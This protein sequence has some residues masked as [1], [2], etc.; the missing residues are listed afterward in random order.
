MQCR[1]EHHD[2]G[3]GGGCGDPGHVHGPECDHEIEDPEG[4]SLYGFIDTSK[5]TALNESVTGSCVNP[6]KPYSKV[7]VHGCCIRCMPSTMLRVLRASGI[8]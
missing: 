8:P 6:F 1:G 7:R 5:L 4:Q 2:H 3:G